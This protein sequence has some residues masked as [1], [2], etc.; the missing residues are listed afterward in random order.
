MSDSIGGWAA[1]AELL[2]ISADSRAMVLDEVL[3]RVDVV[4]IGEHAVLGM[5]MLKGVT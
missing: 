5:A 3:G 1:A 2:A 4:M